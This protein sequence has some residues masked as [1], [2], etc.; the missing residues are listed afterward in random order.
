M[1]L[2]VC[3]LAASV[4]AL[5]A[6]CADGTPPPCRG[7]ARVPTVNRVAVLPFENRAR[8]TSLTLLAEGLADLSGDSRFAELLARIRPLER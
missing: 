3:A 2:Y 5:H 6:Q 8:D 4:R 1:G 7:A